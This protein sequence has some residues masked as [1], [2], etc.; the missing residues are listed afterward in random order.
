MQVWI[1][2]KFIL[3]LTAHRWQKLSIGYRQGYG[4]IYNVKVDDRDI[5]NDDCIE[6]YLEF[7]SEKKIRGAL[8][9][10]VHFI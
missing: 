3:I 4:K 2:Q 6:N 10:K 5:R 9:K 7:K 1:L 8:Y